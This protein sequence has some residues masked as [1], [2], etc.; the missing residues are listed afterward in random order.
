MRKVYKVLVDEAVEVTTAA[1]TATKPPSFKWSSRV[2]RYYPPSLSP[3]SPKNKHGVSVCV[4]ECVR[5]CQLYTHLTH[6]TSS[7]IHHLSRL[8]QDPQETVTSQNPPSPPHTTSTGWMLPILFQ[9][10]ST[11][12]FFRSFVLFFKQARKLEAVGVESGPESA[13]P[14]VC[15]SLPG[16][17]GWG[18]GF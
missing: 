2:N 6:E 1:L 12:S 10:A 3:E 13:L 8:G 18:W 11:L 15:L 9:A 7:S 5:V 4:N 16:D 14:S 17:S